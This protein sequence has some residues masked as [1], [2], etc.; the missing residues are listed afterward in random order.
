MGWLFVAGLCLATACARTGEI[1]D[2]IGPAAKPAA[3]ET[4]LAAAAH[5]Q[6]KLQA[7]AEGIEGRDHA[8]RIWIREAAK[9]RLE[10]RMANP[11]GDR[12]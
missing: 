6:L 8:S 2:S 3:G 10:L 5:R 1:N 11:T 4:D 9:Q 12:K 7:A